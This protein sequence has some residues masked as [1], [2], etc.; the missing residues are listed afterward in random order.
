VIA[1]V[2][3][4]VVSGETL[5]QAAM[6]D[7]VRA[8]VSGDENELQIAALLGA[9]RA[10]GETVEE[11][12]GAAEAMRALAVELPRAPEHAVDTA[13]TGGDGAD[14]FN[15]STVAALVVAGAGV[16]VCKHGNRAASSRC[17]SAELLEELGI[18]LDTPP[19]RMAE[20]VDAVGICFLYARACHPAMAAVGGIRAALGV[21]TIFNRLGPLTNPMRVRRQLLGV[22]RAEDARDALEVLVRLGCESAWIVH[23]EDGLDEVST[24]AP[25]RVLSYHAGEIETFQIEPGQH[26]ARARSQDLAGGPAEQNA[27]IARAILAGEKGPR[28]D[29]VVM[30]AAA[31]LCAALHCDELGEAVAAAEA[32]LDTGAAHGVLERWVEFAAGGAAT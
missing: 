15:I 16:P 3:R 10:R 30:N 26:V 8:I 18:A 11:I 29:V 4:R 23:G 1:G 19:V 7:V 28:R 24:A 13:G 5:E 9:L 25:T 27:A 21:P 17:G 32:S 12:A 14:T 31:A 2:L 22:A 20:S 6:G